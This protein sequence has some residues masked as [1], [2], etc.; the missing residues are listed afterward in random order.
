MQIS[1]LK[2]QL[3]TLLKECYPTHLRYQEHSTAID[4]LVQF[5]EINMDA[6]AEPDVRVRTPFKRPP[7]VLSGDPAAHAPGG[8]APLPV[9]AAAVVEPVEP[10]DVVVETVEPAVVVEPPVIEPVSKSDKKQ[11]SFFKSKDDFKSNEPAAVV[12]P[13]EPV[14]PSE[15]E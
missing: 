8:D 12:E 3:Y 7:H 4:R 1:Q 10:A 2:D 6:K 15:D 13:V 14:T 5:M 11:K 9:E